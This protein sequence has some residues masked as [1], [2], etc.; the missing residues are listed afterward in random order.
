MVNDQAVIFLHFNITM[1]N[2]ISFSNNHILLF[3]KE[4]STNIRFI[5]LRSNL[6]IFL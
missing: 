2:I 4:S 1:F 5:G 3:Y 6:K